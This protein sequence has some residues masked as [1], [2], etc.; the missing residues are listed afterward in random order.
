MVIAVNLDFRPL[1]LRGGITILRGQRKNL[2]PRQ[3]KGIAMADFHLPEPPIG[4]AP[5]FELKPD[6]DGLMNG[7]HATLAAGYEATQRARAAAEAS[8]GNQ[9]DTP[10][11]RHLNARDRS[12]KI[13]QGVTERYNRT[14]TVLNA[15][16]DRLER[17]TRMPPK[18][19][20]ARDQLR[21]NEICSALRAK[22]PEERRAAL[23]N[24]IKSGNGDDGVAAVL[25]MP[26]FVSGFSETEAEEMRLNWRAARYPQEVARLT[27][28]HRLREEFDRSGQLLV[29]YSSKLYDRRVVADGERSQQAAT[30]ALRQAGA[31]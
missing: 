6:A 23:L 21:T 24:A 22:K 18:P 11:R 30:E 17:L 29:G 20:D 19:A 15:E 10:A 7:I 8:L 3:T 13:I 5:N 25:N 31:A 26:G 14:H 28:L 1:K 16:I 12:S 4:V 2:H 9:L 27:E